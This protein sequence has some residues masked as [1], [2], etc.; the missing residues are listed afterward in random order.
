MNSDASDQSNDKGNE[1]PS[2]SEESDIVPKDFLMSREKW[3]EFMRRV[4]PPSWKRTNQPDQPDM[5][6]RNSQSDQTSRKNQLDRLDQ[7]D[8]LKTSRLVHPDQPVYL[9]TAVVAK[10][11]CLKSRMD[12]FGISD[13]EASVYSSGNTYYVEM[14]LAGKRYPAM[15]D[16]GSEVTLLPKRLADLSKVRY[17][18][19]KLR[20]ANSTNITL[21][22]E[23]DTIVEIGDL[24][25][26][27]HFI[28]SDQIEEAII[29]V[30]WMKLNRCILSFSDCSLTMQGYCFPLMKKAASGV[31][32]VILGT[33]V[34][35]PIGHVSP[36]RDQETVR[37][38][39]ILED[40]VSCLV[41]SPVVCWLIQ[42][43]GLKII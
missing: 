17:S 23:W 7:P 28:V 24:K 11:K 14:K 4:P 30:D 33:Q 38:S 21:I 13:K 8:Q 9:Q 22:G 35:D 1:V 41:A 40:H 36:T 31:N 19:R 42:D 10:K 39:R 15:L 37:F 3:L 12:E 43:R 32:R 25:V 20:A 2:R 34:G 29:G 6:G 27:V 5:L 16:T 18:T 26:P